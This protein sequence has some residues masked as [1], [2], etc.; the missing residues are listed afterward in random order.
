MLRSDEYAAIKADYDRISRVH[1]PRSCFHPDGMSF[2]RSDAIFPPPVLAETIGTEYEQQCRMLCYGPF[3]PW[4][5]VQAR[6]HGL[7]NLL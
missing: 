7:R 6:F 5:E 1:F 2:A 3:P 4:A